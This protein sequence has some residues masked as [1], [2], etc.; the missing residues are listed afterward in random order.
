MKTQM[1]KNVTM[2]AI[3]FMMTPLL[4]SAQSRLSIAPAA[5]IYKADLDK[6]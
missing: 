2:L 4:A 3:A 1:P 6:M 5:G